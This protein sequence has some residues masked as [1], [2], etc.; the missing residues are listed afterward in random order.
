MKGGRRYGISH[1]L[2][3]R[4]VLGLAHSSR[5]SGCHGLQGLE[6]GARPRQLILAG[7]GCLRGCHR[8]AKSVAVLAPGSRPQIEAVPPGSQ[9]LHGA[10]C[11]RRGNERSGEARRGERRGEERR[12]EA[13]RGET[14]RGEERRGEA[15]RGVKRRGEARRA[16]EKIGVARRGE[17]RGGQ[18]RRGEQGT[19]QG[20]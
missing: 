20:S 1:P 14:R 9:C 16:E 18:T 19:R 11:P 8:A 7:I 10:W 6:L 3:I 5:V 15:R 2:G 17:K 13:R 12:A 4:P